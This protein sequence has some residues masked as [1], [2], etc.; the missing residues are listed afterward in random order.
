[1][2]NCTTCSAST[3]GI[4]PVDAYTGR[5]LP[6]DTAPLDYDGIVGSAPCP[7]CN[8]ARLAVLNSAKSLL[9]QP[10]DR[11]GY[12]KDW[13]GSREALSWRPHLRGG[14][15][16]DPGLLKPIGVIKALLETA[17]RQVAKQGRLLPERSRKS[18]GI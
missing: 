5:R 7:Q 15:P 18:P 10:A 17:G 4:V 16:A 11:D 6:P 9:A 3:P 1:M 2:G 14:R 8:A 12:P 13:N